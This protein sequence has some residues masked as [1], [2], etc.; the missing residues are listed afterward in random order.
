MSDG[1]SFDYLD[2][3]VDGHFFVFVCGLGN[4]WFTV[5]VSLSVCVSSSS[6]ESVRFQI[7]QLGEKLAGLEFKQV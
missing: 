4:S 3:H 2:M 7:Q 5:S 1:C 6:S